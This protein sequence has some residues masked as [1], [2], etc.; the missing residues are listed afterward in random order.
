MDFITY[1][2][3]IDTLFNPNQSLD[4]SDLSD[5][6]DWSDTSDWSDWSNDRDLV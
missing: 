6:S 2:L 3:C 5:K 4:Q 1:W